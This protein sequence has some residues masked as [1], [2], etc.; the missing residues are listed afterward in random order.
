M[1]AFIVAVLIALSVSFLCS[2]A[3]ATLLSLTPAQLALLSSKH[4]GLGALWQGFKAQIERP[5][6]VVLILNTAAHTIGGSVAGAQFDEIFGDEWILVFSLIFTFLMVQYTE[7]LPKTLGVRYNVALAVLLGRPLAWLLKALSSFVALAHWINRPFEGRKRGT[8]ERMATLEELAA[9]AGLARISNLIGT[10]QERIIRGAS[11]LSQMRVR[12]VMIPMEQVTFLSTGQRIVDAVLAAHM[13]PHTR[14]PVIDEGNRDRV[15]GYVNFKEMIYY[16]RTNPNDPSL[17]GIMRPVHFV[18]PDEMASTLLRDFVDKH[19]HIAI[20]SS[21]DGQTLGLVTLEDIVEE[22]V[23]ELEDEFDRLPRM[24]H[25]LSGGTWMV[26]GGFPVQDFARRLGVTLPDATGTLSAWQIRQM[27]KVPA[28][29]D[30]YRLPAEDGRPQM[31]F[32]VRRTRRGQIFEVAV[33]V[34]PQPAII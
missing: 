28:V 9:L 15:V 11:R 12:N 13:D 23:G 25:A 4:K 31:E 30:T 1:I 10:H 6:A 34:K 14:F 32:Q 21:E 2:L 16:M 22:L 8:T 26:G 29:N 17:M 33:N 7:I 20:V 27:G 18:K 19:I 24:C 5:I 3:E